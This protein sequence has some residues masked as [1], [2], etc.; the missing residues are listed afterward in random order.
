[1]KITSR[2]DWM[3]SRRRVSN[4]KGW[5]KVHIVKIVRKD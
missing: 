4:R 5:I 3:R 2:G 1:M